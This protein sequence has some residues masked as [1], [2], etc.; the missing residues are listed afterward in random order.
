MKQITTTKTSHT[1]TINIYIQQTH[2]LS[3]LYGIS[4]A[5][6]NYFSLKFPG[7][8]IYF[9][10]FSEHKLGHATLVQYLDDSVIPQLPI[11]AIDQWSWFLGWP[12]CKCWIPRTQFTNATD[13]VWLDA[14]SLQ[15]LSG[16]NK[17]LKVSIMQLC[18]PRRFINGYKSCYIQPGQYDAQSNALKADS[19]HLS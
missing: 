15:V 14:D 6:Y 7:P 2:T 8:D 1:Q 11:R 10:F 3:L 19:W 4:L 18:S 17:S 9:I 16:I 13:I 12:N 5:K